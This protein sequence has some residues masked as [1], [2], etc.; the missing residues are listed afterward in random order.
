M[1]DQ[2]RQQTLGAAQI[3]VMGPDYGMRDPG[4]GI[5]RIAYTR[6]SYPVSG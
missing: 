4:F 6:I 2:Q 5:S 3:S 1:I